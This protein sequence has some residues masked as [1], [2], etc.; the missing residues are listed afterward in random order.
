MAEDRTEYHRT[1]GDTS[2]PHGTQGP[3]TDKNPDSPRT[4]NLP[5][6]QQEADHSTN[7]T[8]PVKISP[9]HGSGA[10]GRMPGEG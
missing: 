3:N 8:N 5:G 10:P 6:V 2:Q 4:N 9:S 7:P 1:G